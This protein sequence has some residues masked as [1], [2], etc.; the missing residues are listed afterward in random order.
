MQVKA[1][2]KPLP[3][4][5]PLE[6]YE[7]DAANAPEFIAREIEDFKNK[8]EGTSLLQYLMEL[9]D[10]PT[11]MDSSDLKEAKSTILGRCRHGGKGCSA[12]CIQPLTSCCAELPMALHAPAQGWRHRQR[13]SDH[14]HLRR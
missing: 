6:D 12:P 2:R 10:W 13:P 1:T 7:E 8:T 3:S 5:E 9:P 4:M 14:C 11:Q